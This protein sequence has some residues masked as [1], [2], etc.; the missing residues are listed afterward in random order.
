[1]F[2][3]ICATLLFSVRRISA[4]T[5]GSVTWCF[6]EYCITV[7]QGEIAAEAGLCVVI[8]CS[9]TTAYGF[10][11]KHLLWYKCEPSNQKCGDSNMIF[12]S[13]KGNK[14][15]Q[16]GFMGRVS[17]LEP[18][19]RLKNCSIII[20]D[21][22]ESDS[23]LYQLRVNGLLK[24]RKEDGL[25]FNQ[26]V[27]ISV[28]GL[29]QK[30]TVGIPPLAEGQQTTLSCTAPGLCSGSDPEITWTWRGAG[31]KDSP[32][33]GSITAVKTEN[34]TSVTRRRSSTLTFNP[35]AEHHGTNVTCKVSFTN[36]ITTEE[37][38][39]LDLTY[40]KDLNISRNTSVK[41]GEPLNLTCGV[42]SFPPSLITWTR[43]PETH[44]QNQTD[45]HWHNN[46]EAFT[47]RERGMSTFYVLN[48]TPEYSGRY[49]CTAKHLN[50]TLEQYV[51]VNVIYVRSPVI[52]G[53]TTAL[54][55]GA[56]N[57]TCAVE[58]FP[59]SRVT[60]AASGTT[61]RR[62]L[63]TDRQ[64]GTG[65]AASLV[66]PDVAAEDSGRYTCTAE[67]PDGTVTAY[68]D[69]TVT[70]PPR[71]S[72]SSRCDVRS[73]VVTCVCVSEG[74]PLPSISWPLLKNHS[75]YSVVTTVSGHAVNSTATLTLRDH[76]GTSV[77]C[78]SSNDHGEAREDLRV[79][80]TTWDTE[81]LSS[82]PVPWL[83][84]VVAFF[85]GVLLSAALC[86]LVTRCRRKKQKISSN[87]DETHEMVTSHEAPLMN[88]ARAVEDDRT[89]YQESAEGERGAAP[90]VDGEPKDVLYANIDF[91]LL[92]RKSLGGAARSREATETEYA[93]IQK[94]AEEQMDN[95]GGEGVN[96]SG[97]SMAGEDGEDEVAVYSS[98]TD[99]MS[100][101]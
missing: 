78:V 12:H 61:R 69:V 93:E 23:G 83:Q 27:T 54:E 74:L 95:G 15:V 39:T 88:G 38:V 22:T 99:V 68:A 56:L 3:L 86:C 94:V 59:P 45:T 58:S 5:D 92:S 32:I 18:D 96:A 64:N 34:L 48:A 63:D 13:N 60:W 51:D 82:G 49:I 80:Q 90:D 89:H 7:S 40:V 35:S 21:L 46:T 70:W 73:E 1:M 62:G 8:P 50:R 25:T 79:Q 87:Q 29:T 53:S 33:T 91:S 85:T 28:K 75:E 55:G 67:H 43:S 30:P 52:T 66:I 9:F 26:K 11:P 84:V 57:L 31:E 19:V 17:L 100:E 71:F 81:E 47:Q 10:T 97:G 24:N 20:N 65:S 98:V 42:E 6:R 14:K 37:T 72:N 44:T 76:V 2:V 36:N 41:E 4:A 16:A 101:I 77:Q